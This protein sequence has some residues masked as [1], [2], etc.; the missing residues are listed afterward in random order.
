M[1]LR[2]TALGALRPQSWK[3]SQAGDLFASGERRNQAEADTPPVKPWPTRSK[4]S[5]APATQRSPLPET[6]ETGLAA[7]G[8][9]ALGACTQV[10]PPRGIW[11]H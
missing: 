3:G 6:H 8:I 5:G 11:S 10:S 4:H 2:F 7:F 1:T 9:L